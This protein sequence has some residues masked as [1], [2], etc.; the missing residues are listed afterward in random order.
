M[1]IYRLVNDLET[2]PVLFNREHEK[3]GLFDRKGSNGRP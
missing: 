1:D 3:S 2:H